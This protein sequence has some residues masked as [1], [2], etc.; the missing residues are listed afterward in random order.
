MRKPKAVI[1]GLQEDSKKIRAYLKV[2]SDR[3]GQ[4]FDQD[5]TKALGA[6]D[7]YFANLDIFLAGCKQALRR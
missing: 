1:E 3:H 2:L 7:T 4:N 5:E 6:M